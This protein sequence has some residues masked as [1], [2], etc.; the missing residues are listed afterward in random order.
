MQ[1]CSLSHPPSL[2]CQGLPQSSSAPSPMGMHCSLWSCGKHRLWALDWICQVRYQDPQPLLVGRALHWFQCDLEYPV[3][4]EDEEIM[5]GHRW[6]TLSDDSC[7]AV[8]AKA[9]PTLTDN[10]QPAHPSI[11]FM[12]KSMRGS[13]KVSLRAANGAGTFGE[14]LATGLVSNCQAEASVHLSHSAEV[15]SRDAIVAAVV[16]AAT[17]ELVLTERRDGTCVALLSR[18]ETGEVASGIRLASSHPGAGPITHC[19]YI[20]PCVLLDCRMSRSINNM[21]KQITSFV[22]AVLS[23]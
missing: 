13:C 12:M 21:C 11:H 15:E 14:V 2:S 17:G 6:H 22:K 20:S 7:S 10:Q 1:V 5:C 8:S 19:L 23:V 4:L 9:V 3:W 16:Q 18:A